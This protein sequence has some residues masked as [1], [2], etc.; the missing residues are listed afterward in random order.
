MNTQAKDLFTSAHELEFEERESFLAEACGDDGKLRSEV[1]SMLADAAKA[2]AFFAEGNNATVSMDGSGKTSG[3]MSTPPV[4]H[5]KGN[6]GSVAEKAG[7]VIGPYKLLEKMGEGSF[8]VVFMVE[9]T[10]PIKRMVA[11]KIIKPGM[12]TRE[13]ITRFEIERQALAL[14]DH[15]NISKVID[16]GTSETGR[17]YFAMELVKGLPVT[18]YCDTYCLDTRQRLVLFQD[19]CSAV[20]HAHQKGIIHRDLKPSNILVIH[21]DTKPVVKVI[22]F[23]VAKAIKQEL[24]EKPLYT[25]IGQ[26]IGTPQYMSPEQSTTQGGDIDTRCDIYSLG[27]VLYELLTGKTPLGLKKIREAGVEEMYR[28]IRE[29]EPLKPSTRLGSLS[30]EENTSIMRVYHTAPEKLSRQIRGDLDWIVMKALE[31]D[32]D[33]RYETADGFAADIEYYLT[34]KPVTASPPSASYRLGKFARR[35]KSVLTTV[36]LIFA[37]MLVGTVVSIWQAVRATKAEAQAES[38]RSLAEESAAESKAVLDFLENKVLAAAR[39]KSLGGGL[40]IDATIREAI[41]AAIPKIGEAFAGQPLIEAS[42]RHDLGYTYSYLGDYEAAIEQRERAVE[43]RMEELGAEHPDTLATMS[44]LAY[45]YSEIGDYEKAL[46]LGEEALELKKKVLGSEHPDTLV[47]MAKVAA[48]YRNMGRFEEALVLNEKILE[49]KKKVLGANHPNILQAMGNLASSYGNVG[50]V[51]EALD[52]NEQTLKLKKEAL[53]GEH[54]STLASMS[55]LAYSYSLAGRHEESLA[56]KEETLELKRKVMGSE[57]PSTLASMASLASTYGGVGRFE[58]ALTLKEEVLEL[59]KKVLG[60]EHPDT[61]RSMTSLADT[62]EKKGSHLEAQALRKKA[63]ELR[64][65]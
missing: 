49:L 4:G 24:T 59:R 32:R 39:P 23:G 34:D 35:N 54:P 19:I 11:L 47:G 27:V 25:A 18:E 40:G 61:L 57:H 41:D 10:E 31:K 55:S 62:Y 3:K 6:G 65:K 51:D 14:M 42:L 12:D 16:A 44:S 63:A 20:Q 58:E 53:G 7:D 13:V 43:L 2:D 60:F 36:S 48:Y 38:A 33:R 45:S 30:S 37:V 28:L 1:E 22:D 8:G 17:P 26:M 52:L 9:Q 56:L 64:G 15:P 46:A 29:E 50:R 5:G 21:H